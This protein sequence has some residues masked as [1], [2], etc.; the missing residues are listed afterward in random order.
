MQNRKR[1]A[2]VYFCAALCLQLADRER[3]AIGAPLSLRHHR[4]FGGVD[5]RMAPATVDRLMM[6]AYPASK[7]LGSPSRST[8][9]TLA[10]TP[11]SRIQRARTAFVVFTKDVPCHAL[12][13]LC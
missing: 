7:Q 13:F 11:F 9:A 1:V 4:R 6:G 2:A 8:S 3:E 12:P 5:A 10:G